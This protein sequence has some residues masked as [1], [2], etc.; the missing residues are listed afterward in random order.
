MADVYRIQAAID[1]GGNIAPELSKIL[2]TMSAIEKSSKGIETSIGRWA[3]PIDRASASM[4]HVAREMANV[5]RS[6]NRVEREIGRAGKAMQG[7]KAPAGG[8]DREIQKWAAAMQRPLAEIRTMRTATQGVGSAARGVSRSID[9]WAGRINQ[10]AAAMKRMQAASAGIRLP[11]IPHV[12]GGGRQA[13]SS[14]VLRRRGHQSGSHGGS[15]LAE[16]AGVIGGLGTVNYLLEQGAGGVRED[17]RAKNAGLTPEE[18]AKLRAKAAEMSRMYPSLS[19]LGVREQGRLLIPNVGSYDTAMQV[20]PEYLKGQVAL[21]TIAGPGEGA[22]DMEA[23]ARYIDVIGRSMSVTDTNALIDG[24]VRARQLDSE[25]VRSNDYVNAAKAAASPGK[26]LNVDFW[27]RVAPALMSQQGGARTGTD[28]ASAYQNTVVGRAT[29][30]ALLAQEAAGLREGMEVRTKKNGKKE[31]VRNGRLTDEALYN[32]QP[33]EWDKKHLVPV[34]VA[35]GMLP[36]GYA[37]G[38]Y[39]Q[40]L[41]DKQRADGGKFI[42]DMFSSRRGANIHSMM[43]QDMDQIEQFIQRWGKTRGTQDVLSDQG[44]D[45]YVAGQALKTQAANASSALAAPALPSL[46]DQANRLAAALGGLAD[47]LE[48]HPVAAQSGFGVT[49]A[50]VGGLAV[51]GGARLAGMGLAAVLGGAA[52]APVAITIGTVSALTIGALTIPW[53]A[54]SKGLGLDNDSLRGGRVGRSGIPHGGYVAPPK[55]GPYDFS[56][57]LPSAGMPGGKT[58]P[59]LPAPPEQSWGDWWREKTAYRGRGQGGAPGGLGAGGGAAGAAEAIKQAGD[60]IGAAGS[61]AATAGPAAGASASGF[62]AAASG[63]KAAADA[64]N[65]AGVALANLAAR[66]SGM[67]SIGL[68]GGAKP[69][70]GGAVAAPAPGKASSYAPPP[71]SS[72]PIQIASTIMMNER[73]VG[74]AVT[75]HQVAEANVTNGMQTFDNN[76]MITPVGYNAPFVG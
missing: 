6:A 30:P 28:L 40:D 22:K 20:L 19:Q 51:A 52:A 46:T 70:A 11:T 29:V 68:P 21:Q 26:A 10:A 71:R 42:S 73:A 53:G 39:S 57:G 76:T 7:L 25:A 9:S 48:K 65:G 74:R 34:M 24:Y 60:A 67:G 4:G 27:S 45:P 32:A 43:I 5:Q 62:E 15:H 36:K 54:I 35:N 18:N 16:A 12:T 61:A 64:A 31:I 44:K 56:A 8:M 38:D 17:L 72:A 55:V 1:L 66:I 13:S 47:T 49:T 59:A 50:A 14:T 23:F 63:A 37:K 58:M 3:S 41:T 69:T 75:R 2:K 33:Y